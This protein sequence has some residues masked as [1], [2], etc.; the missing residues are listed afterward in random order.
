MISFVRQNCRPQKDNRSNHERPAAD[1][2]GGPPSGQ[3]GGGGRIV[4]VGSQP[5]E[6][7]FQ[8]PQPGL[9][10]RGEASSGMI[11]TLRMPKPS[12]SAS[13]LSPGFK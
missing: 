2:L 5:D 1:V 13:I 3:P 6:Q 9:G 11:S 4:S 8:V 12:I 10:V 7:T